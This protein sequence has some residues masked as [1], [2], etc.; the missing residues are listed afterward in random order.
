MIEYLGIVYGLGRSVASDLKWKEE[1]KPV[2]RD[3]L[4]ASRFAANAE[5][6]GLRLYWA[7]ADRGISEVERSGY[8]VLY[9][10]DKFR[11][12]RRRIVRKHSGRVIL[13]LMG[14]HERADVSSKI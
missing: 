8:E 5:K 3:W 9:E 4:Q 11:R 10:V 6:D 1:D 14:K 12:V 7:D 13:V 2:D